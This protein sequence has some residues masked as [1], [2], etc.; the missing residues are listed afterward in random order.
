VP[1]SVFLACSDCGVDL[2]LNEAEL[3]TLETDLEGRM[4]CPSCGAFSAQVRSKLGSKHMS[5]VPPLQDLGEAAD[6]GW[7]GRALE[8][9]RGERVFRLRDLDRLRRLVV[10]RKAVGSD[11]VSA[12]G[13]RWVPLATIPALE[14][15]LAVV[16]F[17]D[18]APKTGGGG[19]VLVE[20]TAAEDGWDDE[21]PPHA[22]DDDIPLA[23][24]DE[25]QEPP[26]TS[27]S[28]E[29]S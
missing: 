11:L 23:D 14:P 22:A 4:R 9:R 18:S 10:E 2:E 3:G 12:D 17:L 26:Q 5:Q 25:I 8:L 7:A 1:V 6:E 20:A 16:R 29:L 28:T 13:V 19:G 24:T 27:R 15:F 21:E